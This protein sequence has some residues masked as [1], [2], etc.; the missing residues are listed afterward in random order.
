MKRLLIILSIATFIGAGCG[1]PTTVSETPSVIGG[2][3]QAT[4]TTEVVKDP[5]RWDRTETPGGWKFTPPNGYWV[6]S[7][8]PLRTLYLIPGV[9]PKP[10]SEDPR[11]TEVPK[12]IATMTELQ[13]DPTSFPTWERFTVTMAQFGCA[14][15]TSEADFVTCSDKKTNVSTGKT[16]GGFPYE[17]FSLP[18]TLKKTGASRG[19]RTFIAIHL[20][21]GSNDGIMLSVLNESKASVALDLATSISR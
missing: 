10:D 3:T 13:N 2:G 19:L 9:T 20:A 5:T 1:K 12:A 15:G 4:T 18:A 14:S 17:K 16:A 7:I 8:E 11:P 6:A 21:D